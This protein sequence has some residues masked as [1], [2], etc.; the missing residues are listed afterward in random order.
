VPNSLLTI[1]MV[2]REALRVAHESCQFIATTDLQYDG[3]FGKTG[4]KIGSTLRVRKP[5]QYSRTQGSRVMDVQ[6]QAEISGTITV[7][8]Q[9]HVDMRFNSAEMAL[10]LDDFSKRYIEPAV[11]VL[12]SG[13]ESDYLAFATKATY[14]LV[15]TA[16]TPITS[17][18]VPSAARAKLNQGLAPKDKNRAIQ[19]DSVT[20]GGLVN[21][22]ATYFNPSNAIGEQYREGLV[23]RTSMADY[24]E[25]ERVW[26]MTNGDDVAWAV[27]ESTETNFVQGATVLHMD[28]AGTASGIQNGSVFTIADMFA[29]HP[30]TKAR[31]P[32][33][34]QFVVVS[35]A[36]ASS[37]DVDI[38][39]SPAI[40]T[41]GPRKNVCTATGAD[42]TWT[43]AAQNDKVVTLV[44]AASTGY[45][46]PLM[47]HKEAFQFVTA[48]LP[49]M[50]DA[51]KCVRRV[52]DNLS[53]RVWQ[54]SDIRNDEQL[55]RIDILYGFAAL[56]PE[57]ACRMI[58]AAN[59]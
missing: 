27:D 25:N 23:A 58:G 44:G 4:A 11:K 37:A 15:G 24:Y 36:N 34:Q 7:A 8:T 17:L 3:S 29:C 43:S 56:R 20:M 21:G 51:A 52:Q 41:T 1:D 14:N 35:S 28:A 42:I 49:L 10:E 50:D 13:I 2:T 57:W 55:M 38:T 47:Y 12:V 5:N 46:Q 33:L 30:E 32:H 53:L 48:D 40:Y 16:G 18:V 45:V 9:D 39:F 54:A 26:S 31:L 59:T 22:V 19:M 6:D